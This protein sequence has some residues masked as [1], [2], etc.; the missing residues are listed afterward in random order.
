MSDFN[1]LWKQVDGKIPPGMQVK[2]DRQ[3]LRSLVGQF[4]D[5]GTRHAN[6]RHR[7]KAKE[8]QEVF[9]EADKM[10]VKMDEMFDE[11]DEGFKKTFTKMKRFFKR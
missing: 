5:A 7:A 1:T 2:M 6:D 10:F 3:N 4:Y 9:D 11:M 8:A